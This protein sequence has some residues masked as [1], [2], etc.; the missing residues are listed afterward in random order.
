MIRLPLIF[1]LFLCLSCN[2][3]NPTSALHTF[4]DKQIS[5]EQIIK[6]V[7]S[8]FNT[9]DSTIIN[10][11]EHYYSKYSDSEIITASLFVEKKIIKK[12]TFDFINIRP[13]DTVDIFYDNTPLI[14]YFDDAGGLIGRKENS[15]PGSK[16]YAGEAYVNN[17]TLFFYRDSMNGLKKEE[18]SD[19]TSFFYKAN[20]E[21]Y[22]CSF[23]FNK[24]YRVKSIR[25]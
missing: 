15:S 3:V 21:W 17:H 12:L 10:I 14:Y 23:L 13:N 24:K 9:I 4:T 16:T 7:D 25:K 19:D 11:S 22:L 1:L 18:Y 2:N 5:D 20:I 8:I 6:N